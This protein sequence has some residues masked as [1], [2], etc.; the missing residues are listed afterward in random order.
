MSDPTRGQELALTMID[1]AE[2]AEAS[3]QIGNELL[4]NAAGNIV[5]AT[6]ITLPMTRIVQLEEFDRWA[7]YTRDLIAAAPVKS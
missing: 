2:A 5:V 7:A 6:F 3:G 4:L 1:A